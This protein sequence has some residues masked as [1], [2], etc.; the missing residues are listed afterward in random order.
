[1]LC[2]YP[3]LTDLSQDRQALKNLDFRRDSGVCSIDHLHKQIELDTTSTDFSLL[4]KV[5]LDGSVQPKKCPLSSGITLKS[6]AN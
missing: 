1:M 3:K 5:S 4:K 2:F 6:T